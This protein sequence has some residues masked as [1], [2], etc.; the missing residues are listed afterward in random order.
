[1]DNPAAEDADPAPV[2]PAII[3]TGHTHRVSVQADNGSAL[4]RSATPGRAGAVEVSEASPEGPTVTHRPAGRDALPEGDAGAR[5]RAA[6]QRAA[7]REP[8]RGPGPWTP[9][10]P[11]EAGRARAAQA[12]AA[13]QDRLSALRGALERTAGQVD[14]LENMLK[15]MTISK[16]PS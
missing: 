2:V 13:L 9:S 16:E 12:D 7:R 15:G 8:A 1:M 4:S 5:R 3:H 6:A 14:Q 11:D 10:L